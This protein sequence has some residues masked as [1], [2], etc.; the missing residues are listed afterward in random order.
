MARKYIKWLEHKHQREHGEP[1]NI[2]SWDSAEGVKQ[3]G[4]YSVDGFI[5]R[6]GHDAGDLVLEIN[7][8]YW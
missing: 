3:I 7:G 1:L 2:Q 5:Q 4:P 6:A 8:C